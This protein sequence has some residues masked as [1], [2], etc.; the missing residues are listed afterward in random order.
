MTLSFYTAGLA[1][2]HDKTIDPDL[3]WW[4]WTVRGEPGDSY[5]FDAADVATTDIGT[6]GG[7]LIN[8]TQLENVVYSESV[9]GV[10]TDGL[11]TAD[12]VLVPYILGSEGTQGPWT[13]GIIISAGSDTAS[14]STVIAYMDFGLDG[15]PHKVYGGRTITIEWPDRE[16]LWTDGPQ[17]TFGFETAPAGGAHEAYPPAVRNAPPSRTDYDWSVAELSRYFLQ[18]YL[19]DE[20]AAQ[21]LQTGITVPTPAASA[22]DIVVDDDSAP[23]PQG[24]PHVRLVILSAED[25]NPV[26]IGRT[27]T[28]YS[29]ELR[30]MV[31]GQLRAGGT[32]PAESSRQ[33]SI[34]CRAVQLVLE[35]HLIGNRGIRDARLLG[36]PRPRKRSSVLPITTVVNAATLRVTQRTYSSRQEAEIG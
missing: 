18:E 27:R 2:L 22:I 36:R 7:Y 3:A 17:F 23:P 10:G 11:L 31:S 32:T 4:C 25:R 33:A 12:P 14:S 30:C 13:T 9:F 1:G 5:E 34:L 8:G 16:V 26:N 20:L 24:Y 28:A 21:N 15:I 19:P 35:G 6:A 29:L